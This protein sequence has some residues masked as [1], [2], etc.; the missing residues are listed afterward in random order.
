[1][2]K[3]PSFAAVVAIFSVAGVALSAAPAFAGSQDAASPYALQA[4]VVNGQ[5]VYCAVKN[6]NSYELPYHGCMTKTRWAQ[7]G[8]AVSDGPQNQIAANTAKEK[9][10]GSARN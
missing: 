9:G 5:T 3:S 7:H 1:M 8:I 2:F 10:K 4:K 6:E